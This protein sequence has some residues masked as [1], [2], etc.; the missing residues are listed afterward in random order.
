MLGDIELAQLL[1][2]GPL[3]SPNTKLPEK[4]ARAAACRV[5]FSIAKKYLVEDRNNRNSPIVKFL[6]CLGLAFDPDSAPRYLIPR[7]KIYF[8][9]IS[10]RADAAAIK[11]FQIVEEVWWLNL[12]GKPGISLVAKKYGMDSSAVSRIWSKPAAKEAVQAFTR[13]LTKDWG[14]LIKDWDRPRH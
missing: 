8:K 1:L 9:G 14:R 7:Q 2:D 3:W 5:L 6:I 4:A 10:K 11:H 12:Q 13:R